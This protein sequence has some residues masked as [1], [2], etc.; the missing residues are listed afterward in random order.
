MRL[1]LFVFLFQVS[2][3]ALDTSYRELSKKIIRDLDY[4]YQGR[5]WSGGST[6][7]KETKYRYDFKSISEYEIEITR[8]IDGLCLDEPFILDL[9]KEYYVELEAD[10]KCDP[11]V[12]ISHGVDII[13]LYVKDRCG[14][15]G[16]FN[17]YKRAED[18]VVLLKEHLYKASKL[19]I[20]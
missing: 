12:K 14:N 1:F 10:T 17:L 20:E 3:S 2:L 5:A 11:A 6:F 19:S 8:N 13:Y 15:F 18:A 9:R 4:I 7:A 16:G